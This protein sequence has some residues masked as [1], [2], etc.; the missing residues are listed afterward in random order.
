[1][2]IQKNLT[3]INVFSF[4]KTSNHLSSVEVMF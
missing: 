2:K 4:H 3:K 1:L